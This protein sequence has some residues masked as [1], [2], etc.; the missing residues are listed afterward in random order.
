MVINECPVL[1]IFSVRLR[2]DFYPPELDEFAKWEPQCY[3]F[4]DDL[5]NEVIN[6]KTVENLFTRWMHHN[7]LIVIYI[8]Q[9]LF[10]QGKNALKYDT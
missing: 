2:E 4:F 10:Q 9:N 3:F 8:T 7:N 6:S 1:R 5:Q